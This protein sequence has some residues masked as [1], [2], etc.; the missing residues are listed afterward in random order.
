MFSASVSLIWLLAGWATFI[1][2][3]VALLDVFGRQP[4]AFPYLD[5]LTKP[6]WIAIAALSCVSHFIFGAF[7]VFGLVGLVACSVYLVDIRPKIIELNKN[8]R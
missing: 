3:A 5:R 6:A 1:V 4:E 7:G 2:K 8:G